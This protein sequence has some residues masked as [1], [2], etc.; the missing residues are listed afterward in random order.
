MCVCVLAVLL[1]VT[2]LWSSL[3]EELSCSA[4]PSSCI[5]LQEDGTFALEDEAGSVPIDLTGARAAAGLVTGRFSGFLSAGG[6]TH[7]HVAPCARFWLGQL[8]TRF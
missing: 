8:Q 5:C 4:A 7:V 3:L 1:W 6:L 2:S